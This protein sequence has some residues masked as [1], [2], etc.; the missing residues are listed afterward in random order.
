MAWPYGPARVSLPLEG[1]L[2]LGPGS[3]SSQAS[4][5]PGSQSHFSHFSGS[6]GSRSPPALHRLADLLEKHR[7]ELHQELHKA[8]L[9]MQP[10]STPS[11]TPRR[12]ARRPA[13]PP[14]AAAACQVELDGGQFSSRCASG[15]SLPAL[16]ELHALAA[17]T[18]VMEDQSSRARP[19]E[20]SF[21][22]GAEF[23]SV[24][25]D[26]LFV[27]GPQ[28]RYGEQPVIGSIEQELAGQ[29]SGGTPYMPPAYFTR[30]DTP[31]PY[32][33]EENAF[34]RRH[35][36]KEVKAIAGTGETKISRGWIQVH[37]MKFDG[38]A[39]PTEPPEGAKAGDTGID[40]KG[41]VSS[42]G[43]GSEDS[44]RDDEKDVAWSPEL[45]L[46][47]PVGDG[48]CGTAFCEC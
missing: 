19:P 35:R 28:L 24:L 25:A 8:R 48:A 15:P 11:S 13:A 21:E 18:A 32:D 3:P 5:S 14:K 22:T 43:I 36:N 9:I 12:P 34:L 4:P 7:T 29:S 40:S 45:G 20:R 39:V 33:F 47:S 41:D 23:R 44:L 6:H 38:G 26:F 10:V 16:E 42:A 17:R 2:R 37:V 31:Q 1:A 30:V 27:P 46:K